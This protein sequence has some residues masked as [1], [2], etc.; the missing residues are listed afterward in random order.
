MNIVIAAISSATQLSGVT[1]HAANLVRCLLT[2]SEISDV[3]LIGAPWQH[4]LLR[5]AV[6]RDDSRL[7]IHSVPLGPGTVARNLW[8]YKDLPA[9][10]AQLEAD[11]VHLSYPSPLRASAFHCPTV[12]SLHDLYPYDIPDNFGFPKVF[13]NRGILWQ[14]LRAADGIACVSDNTLHQLAGRASIPVLMKAIRIYNCV[15]PVAVE[16]P[17]P[18]WKGEPFLLCVAQHRRNKNI[19]LTLQIF[20]HLLRCGRI[21]LTTRLI[22]VGVFGPETPQIQRFLR[23]SGLNDRVLLISG[24]RDAELQWCY[25]NCE[26]LLALSS[27]EGFGLPVAE[28]LLAGCRIVCSDILAFRELE[29]KS[30]HYISLIPCALDAFAQKVG[31]ALA[32]PRGEPQHLPQLSVGVI[33]EECLRLYRKLIL[34]RSGDVP[35]VRA[36]RLSGIMFGK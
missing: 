5:D 19:L 12:V 22:I 10:A 3:H 2:R 13:F 28:A 15:E 4:Q 35:V 24:I 26:L 16:S 36:K 34:E 30:C 32:E 31:N 14:C 20:Q 11:V 25:T 33:A 27:V 23:E 18:G 6:S 8:Y 9:I 1:R 21:D 17:L 7:H 29:G